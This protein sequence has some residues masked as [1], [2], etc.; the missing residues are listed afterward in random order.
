MKDITIKEVSVS[1]T[2]TYLITL[3]VD[4]SMVDDKEHLI[5]EVH[6]YIN[7]AAD[8][9]GISPLSLANKDEVEVIEILD[10]WNDYE[11]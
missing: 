4:A 10:E 2:K 8:E 3:R 5:E 11:D 9:F 1:L 6:H 7:D